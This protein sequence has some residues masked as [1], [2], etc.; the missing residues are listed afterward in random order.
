MQTLT[1]ILVPTDF[2][3]CSAA[4]FDAAV[5]LARTTETEIVL[6]HI[7]EPEF[8]YGRYGLP[9]AAIEARREDDDAQLQAELATMRERLGGYDRVRL[10]VRRGRARDAI[11]AAAAEGDYDLI[12]MGTHGRAGVRRMLIGSNAE[13][14]VREAPCPVLTVRASA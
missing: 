10:D 12:V 8:D 13:R 1:K 3:E 4:A 6:L 7:A 11:C 5:A 9:E 14:V 2:S